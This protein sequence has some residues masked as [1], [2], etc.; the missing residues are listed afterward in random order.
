MHMLII[1]G[2]RFVGYQL[3]WRLLAAGHHVT[4]LNRSSRSDSRRGASWSLCVHQ[5]RA[6]LPGTPGLSLAGEGVRL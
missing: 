1:G 5:H 6:G 2:T 3:V 4:M